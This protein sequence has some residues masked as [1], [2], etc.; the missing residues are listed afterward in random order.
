MFSRILI[1]L[2][3][4]TSFAAVNGTFKMSNSR[5]PLTHE[6]LREANVR[7]ETVDYIPVI[8]N[9]AMTNLFK[10][11]IEWVVVNGDTVKYSGDSKPQSISS[12]ETRTTVTQAT[13]VQMPTEETKTSSSITTRSPFDMTK[14]G[15]LVAFGGGTTIRGA[16][17]SAVKQ[18]ETRQLGS[19]TIGMGGN[20]SLRVGY[21]FNRVVSLY[22]GIDI[23]SRGY[24]ILLG[25]SGTEAA[26]YQRGGA[27]LEIPLLFRPILPKFNGNRSLLLAVG[28]APSITLTDTE[29]LYTDKKGLVASSTRDEYLDYDLK[30]PVTIFN[31]LTGES[32]TIEYNDYNRPVNLNLLFSLGLERTLSPKA[33]FFW[34][35]TYRHGLLDMSRRTDAGLAKV[36]R[37]GY[38]FL[39][40]DLKYRSADFAI[41]FN[42]YPNKR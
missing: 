39:D 14:R 36:A 6:I 38:H 32:E 40:Y 33:S 41:G 15:I 27:S 18:M 30:D 19:S 5:F 25:E 34:N 37:L 2:T 9:N 28:V 13:V 3:I 17:G 10:S 20:V 1:L 7:D 16:T 4:T 22:S 26:Y 42:F 11:E 8:K 21:R 12:K 24:R 29:Q 31:E 23:T 35:I